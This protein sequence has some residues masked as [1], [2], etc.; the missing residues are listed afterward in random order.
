MNRSTDQLAESPCWV[1]ESST[2]TIRFFIF[3]VV[4]CMIS[5][6]LSDFLTGD[7][8]QLEIEEIG[9]LLPKNHPCLPFSATVRSPKIALWLRFPTQMLSARWSGVGSFLPSHL[10][11]W[12]CEYCVVGIVLCVQCETGREGEGDVRRQSSP[13]LST[14]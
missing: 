7:A 1:G 8:T 11:S 2:I 12:K 3:R 4:F 9:Y 6:I 14:N 10:P 5:F 13:R